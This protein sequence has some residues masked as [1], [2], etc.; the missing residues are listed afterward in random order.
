MTPEHTKTE[1]GHLSRECNNSIHTALQGHGK[2]QCQNDMFSND[3]RHLRSDIRD[4]FKYLNLDGSFA[5]SL[6]MKQAVQNRNE[7]GIL[8]HRIDQTSGSR[9]VRF[10]LNRINTKVHGKKFRKYGKF[11]SVIPVFERH[12]RWHFHSLMWTPDGWKTGDYINLVLDCWSKTDF[13]HREKKVVRNIDAGWTGYI[14]KFRSVED[15]IDF[16]NLELPTG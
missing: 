6:S 5:L 12:P 4:W 9:Q 10:L 16:A 1:S 2:G 14:T 7:N 8:Y 13:A 3:Y 15:D 11:V